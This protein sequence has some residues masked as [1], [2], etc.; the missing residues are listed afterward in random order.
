MKADNKMITRQKEDDN[1]AEPDAENFIFCAE[2]VAVEKVLCSNSTQSALFKL[3][4]F[5]S[6]EM[7]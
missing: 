7:L 4:C 2:P 6:K 1:K 5:Y 3:V